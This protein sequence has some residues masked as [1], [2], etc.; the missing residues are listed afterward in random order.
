MLYGSVDIEGAWR[1]D[2]LR[3]LRVHLNM[4]DCTHDEK[5]RGVIG[6]TFDNQHWEGRIEADHSLGSGVI[7]VQLDR[8]D[9]TLSGREAFLLAADIGRFALFL[10]ERYNIGRLGLEAG[11]R[12]E[13]TLLTPMN[14]A[15]ERSF[16]GVSS[17]LGLSY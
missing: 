10:L 17:S 6:T 1:L 9:M 8:R 7:G 16:S 11:A 13:R 14:A 12:F 2:S 15:N 4:S 5:E 3:G